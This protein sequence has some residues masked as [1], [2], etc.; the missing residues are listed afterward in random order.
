MCSLT[1]SLFL[2]PLTL[3]PFTTSL[4][5]FSQL[6]GAVA[7]TLSDCEAAIDLFPIISTPDP[8]TAS[9]AHLNITLTIPNGEL[10]YYKMPAAFV[11][12]SCAVI[13][14]FDNVPS[15]QRLTASELDF[16][17][18][19]QVQ[20]LAQRIMARCVARPIRNLWGGAAAGT[21]DNRHPYKVLVEGWVYNVYTPH[22]KLET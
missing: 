19:P 4:G 3:L 5:C 12:G 17:F 2:L 21:I 16:S 14:E 7:P 13:I 8:R 11:V 22:G 9:G 1:Y 10:H 20:S 18:W 15:S 6:P